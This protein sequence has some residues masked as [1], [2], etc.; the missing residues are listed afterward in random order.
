MSKIFKNFPVSLRHV[1]VVVIVRVFM[2]DRSRPEN[3]D[4]AVFSS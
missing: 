1:T 3:W 2:I 4:W